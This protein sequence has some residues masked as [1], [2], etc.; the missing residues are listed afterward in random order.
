MIM[1]EN[2]LFSFTQAVG[3]HPPTNEEPTA[4]TIHQ[5]NEL[6]VI[7]K[8]LLGLS[9]NDFRKYVAR[10]HEPETMR[11]FFDVV[12]DSVENAAALWIN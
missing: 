7:Q 8:S 10:T 6:E 12:S 9:F 2:Y 4:P 5:L 1:M 3:R 11:T